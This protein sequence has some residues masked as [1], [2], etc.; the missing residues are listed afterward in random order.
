M[1][2]AP[3]TPFDDRGIDVGF[4][5]AVGPGYTRVAI[6][7]FMDELAHAARKDPLAFRMAHL[8]ARAPTRC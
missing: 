7:T 2:V 3:D 1:E 8:Q 4:W 6:E 5:R